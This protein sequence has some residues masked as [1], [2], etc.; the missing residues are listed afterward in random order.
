MIEVFQ[1]KQLTIQTVEEY[2]L[3]LDAIKNS[4]LSKFIKIETLNFALSESDKFLLTYENAALKQV[5]K[6]SDCDLDPLY[7]KAIDLIQLIDLNVV[8]LNSYLYLDQINKRKIKY[9][10][11]IIVNWNDE[12][13][14]EDIT[15]SLKYI[16]DNSIVVNCLILLFDTNYKINID[17][18]NWIH[19]KLFNSVQIKSI[20]YYLNSTHWENI[21]SCFYFCQNQVNNK[22]KYLLIKP[23]EDIFLL[24]RESNIHWDVKR[25]LMKFWLTG[26]S[27]IFGYNKSLNKYSW[28]KV[29][30]WSFIVNQ[31]EGNKFR[32]I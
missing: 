4:K 3:F 28:V 20:N 16:E 6:D 22:Q 26:D 30:N 11:K 13:N 32:S 19:S 18:D 5:Y 21:H 7:C 31:T 15:M 9:V 24:E 8:S 14:T 1:I 29:S 17:Q 10:D 27:F 12:I 23:D 2:T 25:E